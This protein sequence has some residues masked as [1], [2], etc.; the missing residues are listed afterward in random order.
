MQTTTLSAPRQLLLWRSFAALIGTAAIFDLLFWRQ[1]IGINLGLYAMLISGAL[2][3][4][5]GWIGLS[6]PA[7]AAFAGTLLCCAMVVVHNSVV[8]IIAG[9]VCLFITAALA[10]EAKLRS[11]YYGIAQVVAGY[12]M[13]PMG[14]SRSV[15]EAMDGGIATRKAWRWFRLALIPLALLVIYFQIYRVANPKFD[16]LTA[17]FLDTLG[18][19]VVRPLQ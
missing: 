16:D 10:H 15:G 2:V 7:R 8:S 13:M 18:P 14:L 6:G 12:I 19:L 4:R 9:F 11:L 3:L 1:D 17:G 5:Y